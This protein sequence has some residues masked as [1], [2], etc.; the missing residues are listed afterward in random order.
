MGLRV[1]AYQPR[2]WQAR[3]NSSA[4]IAPRNPSRG[5]STPPP[6]VL[7]LSLAKDCAK[8]WVAV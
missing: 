1:E 3:L 5:G 4:V 6:S 2:E 8:I 7:A